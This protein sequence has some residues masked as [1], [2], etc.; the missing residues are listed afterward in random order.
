[1][2]NV[3]K[4]INNKLKKLFFLKKKKSE[5][6]S[7][8]ELVE[9]GEISNFHGNNRVRNINIG[10][11][12]YVSFNSIIYHTE[13]GNY[14]SVGPNVVIGYGDHPTQMISTS[15]YIYLNNSLFNSEEIN[16][17]LDPHFKKVKIENDVWIG[18]NVF[19]K[20]GVRIGNGAIIGAGSVVL[21][22]VNDYEI[23]GGVPSRLIRKRFNESI[24]D[25]LL[26]IKWWE[27]DLE[28]LKQHTNVIKNPNETD[29][30]K[31][32]IN[33]QQNARY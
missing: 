7:F 29:L 13:I 31:M 32:K 6:L 21:K 17:F 14:C 33:I 11:H 19:I 12:S 27:L 26:E 4:K 15:P 28:F 2:G 16:G 1:M 3:I 5:N 25:L 24:I 22:D 8:E 9:L 30:I 20:N 18:A 10:K 23:V